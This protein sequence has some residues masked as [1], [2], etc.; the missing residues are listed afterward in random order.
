MSPPSQIHLSVTVAAAGDEQREEK[1]ESEQQH[2]VLV[3][4]PN[5]RCQP[6]KGPQPLVPGSHDAQSKRRAEHPKYRLE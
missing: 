1:A 5:A 3:Q 2:R 6:E 4:N